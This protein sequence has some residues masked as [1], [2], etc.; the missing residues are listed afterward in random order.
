MPSISVIIVSY[1]RPDAL[2]AC[3][4]SLLAQEYTRF[5]IIIADDGSTSYTKDL[6]S[7][8]I[9]TYQIQI[10]HVFQEDNGFRAGTIR[11]KAV[12]IST[13]SYLIFMDGDCIALPHFISRHRKLAREKCFVPGNRILLSKDYSHEVLSNRILFHNK[14]PH[15]FLMLRLTGKINR[16]APLFHLPLGPLRNLQPKRW[17]RAMTCNLGMWKGDFIDVNGFD[18]A[19]EG[20]G[21]EDSD[22][23]VRL[24]QNRVMRKEGR[25]ALP[26]FH[27]WHEHHDLENHDRNYQRLLDWIEEKNFHQ[28]EKG[29]KQYL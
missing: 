20:W 18:E 19:F 16:L 3:L 14:S 24:I 5:E 25:F 9:N 22:L 6:V 23:V 26:V 21:Y 12:A 1:N 13:G 17:K 10:K 7:Y 28:V 15:F 29:V 8:Y 27:L 2:E 11:N 4:Q